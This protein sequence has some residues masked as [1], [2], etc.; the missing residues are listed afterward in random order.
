MAIRIKPMG[1]RR[2]IDRAKGLP[3]RNLA[4]YAPRDD[5]RFER[6]YISGL[7]DESE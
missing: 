5:G 7:M 3:E 1:Q 2:K 4:V 6:P